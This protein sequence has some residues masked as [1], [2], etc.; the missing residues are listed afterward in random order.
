MPR[1]GDGRPLLAAREP[2]GH[3]GERRPDLHLRR[4][5]RSAARRP[6][7]DRRLRAAPRLPGCPGCRPHAAAAERPRRHRGQV[8][9]AVHPL[10]RR[11]TCHWRGLLPRHAGAG[12]GAAG[13]GSGGRRGPRAVDAPGLVL[14][15]LEPC[16]AD[17]GV[18]LWRWLLQQLSRRPLCCRARR[19]RGVRLRGLCRGRGP[20]RLAVL[21]QAQRRAAPGGGRRARGRAPRHPRRPHAR[22]R[23]H[24]GVRRLGR[25]RA[26]RHRA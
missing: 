13:L 26:G 14:G 3:A 15:L 17:G 9:V 2:L 6:L 16:C 19:A 4:L 21:G 23:R 10:R 20:G 22:L 18:C 5:Q 7:G 11:G 24:A 12:H 1:R 8:A 25:G